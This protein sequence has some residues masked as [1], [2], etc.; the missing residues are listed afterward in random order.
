MVKPSGEK[1]QRL[2]ARLHE[3]QGGLC[4]FCQRDVPL[5]QPIK[6]G[7]VP[8][9]YPT[10]DHKIP[11][12]QGGTWIKSNLVLACFSCNHIKGNG[13][14]PDE[15]WNDRERMTVVFRNGDIKQF[16]IRPEVQVA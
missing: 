8:R 11:L 3:A 12:N 9:N 6:Q 7:R 4:L 15:I 5:D 14:I 10:L 2:L 13:I 1:K 16:L